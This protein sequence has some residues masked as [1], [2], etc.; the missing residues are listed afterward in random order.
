MPLPAVL[1]ESLARPRARTPA[2]LVII[3]LS[4]EMERQLVR[5]A[6]RSTV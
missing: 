1:M 4:G 3:R 6:R 2:S 5:A